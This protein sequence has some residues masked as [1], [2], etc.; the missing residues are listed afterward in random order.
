[1]NNI[2]IAKE[3]IALSRALI[4]DEELNEDMQYFNNNVVNAK[5][6]GFTTV[7][8]NNEIKFIYDADETE[9]CYITFQNDGSEYGYT[10]I[11]NDQETKSVSKS[12]CEQAF[13]DLSDHIDTY[14]K[15]FDVFLKKIKEQTLQKVETYENLGTY[16]LIK[17]KMNDLRYKAVLTPDF[18]A[19]DKIIQKSIN[20]FKKEL[21][22]QM[23]S[24]KQNSRFTFIITL[25][26]ESDINFV[27]DNL[28]SYGWNRR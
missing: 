6:N 23:I 24:I 17:S 19:D 26:N 5:F 20:E 27:E 12:T 4:A 21:S 13:K 15:S 28:E 16:K 9:S 18:N 22:S 10:V 8:E 2:K 11:V 25:M 1:M 7:V 3:L 14:V